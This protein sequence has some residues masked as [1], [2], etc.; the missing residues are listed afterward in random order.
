MSNSCNPIDCSLPGF[1]VRGILQGR[2]L[3]WV[4]IPFRRGSSQP[5]DQTWVSCIAGRFFTFWA[6]NKKELC[7]KLGFHINERVTRNAETHRNTDWILGDQLE[8]RASSSSKDSFEWEYLENMFSEPSYK[9][10]RVP[11][12]HWSREEVEAGME[13]GQVAFLWSHVK[14]DWEGDELDFFALVLSPA[15]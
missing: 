10:T 14:G 9:C 6:K 2:I 5:R 7:Y 1:S 15:L 4:A 8:L 12:T 11:S 3:E 13:L